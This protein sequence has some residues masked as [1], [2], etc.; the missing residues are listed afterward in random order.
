MWN[1]QAVTCFCVVGR[2]EN[3]LS[4]IP[5]LSRFLSIST[6]SKEGMYKSCVPCATDMNNQVSGGHQG[7]SLST[8]S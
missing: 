4:V 7:N 1:L 5:N 8:P 2:S 6:Q 3:L